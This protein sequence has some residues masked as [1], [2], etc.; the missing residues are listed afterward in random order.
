MVNKL[1]QRQKDIQ[2]VLSEHEEAC[3]G[4]RQDGLGAEVIKGLEGK[5]LAID[6]RC[7]TCN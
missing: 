5:L 4:D 3:R 7:V 6:T 2:R 1:V